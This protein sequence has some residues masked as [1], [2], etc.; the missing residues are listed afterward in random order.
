MPALSFNCN[1]LDR[2][3]APLIKPA[4][5]GLARQLVKVGA[6][7]DQVTLL[8]FALGL[9]AAVLIAFQYYLTGA[10]MVLLSRLCDALDGAVARQTE[11]TDA[12]GFLDISLDFLFYASI[13]LAFAIADPVANALPA[14]VLLAAFMGTGSSFLAFAALAA[15]RGLTNIDYPHKSFYFLGGLAEAT[16]TLAFFMAMCLWPQHFE[17]LAYLYAAVCCVTIATR[18]YGGWRSL[19]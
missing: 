9:C 12:G 7:A 11:A 13:P 10:A 15:K 1:M 18:I 4:M 5:D 3:I 6:K 16:E 17:V 14:A 19:R 2:H 8:A